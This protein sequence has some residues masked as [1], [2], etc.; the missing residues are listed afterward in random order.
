MPLLD[1]TLILNKLSQRTILDAVIVVLLKHFTFILIIND[2]IC[3]ESR[4]PKI[5][6]PD[7]CCDWK[8]AWRVLAILEINSIPFHLSLLGLTRLINDQNNNDHRS[9]KWIKGLDK[10]CWWCHLTN[11]ILGNWFPSVVITKVTRDIWFE[12]ISIHFIQ[13]FSIQLE[14]KNKLNYHQ[15]ANVYEMHNWTMC[16]AWLNSI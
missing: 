5:R 2:G 4:Y 9:G 15:H 8:E 14:Q 3:W 7:L 1:Y 11:V 6:D 12:I 16:T 10:T 13:G